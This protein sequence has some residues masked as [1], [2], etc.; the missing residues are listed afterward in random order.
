MALK[1]NESATALDAVISLHRSHG[2]IVL[3]SSNNSSHK[4][5]IIGIESSTHLIE[6]IGDVIY[7]LR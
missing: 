2:D 6:L 5:S 4:N 1:T 3:I 7:M